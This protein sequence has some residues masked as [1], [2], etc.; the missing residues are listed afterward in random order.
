VNNGI[1]QLVKC[2]TITGEW[3]QAGVEADVGTWWWYTMNIR[4]MKVK[5]KVWTITVVVPLT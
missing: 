5:V 1:D 4:P 3:V 2:A